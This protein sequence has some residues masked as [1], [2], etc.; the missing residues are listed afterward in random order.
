MPCMDSGQ[1]ICNISAVTFYEEEKLKLNSVQHSLRNVN[2]PSHLKKLIQ[3]NNWLSNKYMCYD[4]HIE[5]NLI[6]L[7]N[8]DHASSISD[9][10]LAARYRIISREQNQL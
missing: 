3:F 2:Q 9:S 6:H 4:L 5:L 8:S 7:Q 10:K 1:D